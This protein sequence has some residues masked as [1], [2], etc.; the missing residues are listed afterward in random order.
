MGQMIVD[1]VVGVLANGGIRAQ[2]AFPGGKLVRV[3]EPVAAVSLERA[4]P[5]EY[6][7]VVLVEILA[8]QEVGGYLCQ[9]KALEACNLLDAAGGECDQGRCLFDRSSNLFRVPIRVAFHG[10]A[11]PGNVEDVPRP[12]IVAGDMQLPYVTAFSAEQKVSGDVLSLE[13]A[14]W[15]ITV[16]EFFPWGVWNTIEPEQ[17][18]ILE[19]RYMG[20]VE[21]YRHCKWIG[22][23]RIK[24]E[25]GMRQIRK[26]I[27]QS[28]SLTGE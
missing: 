16:E 28:R 9:Q 3:T 22:W 1:K 2:A 25:L 18:F 19:L 24:E 26:G 17:P 20:R 21:Q 13:S 15:E 4:Q 27:A 14:S 6:R 11:R 8:P 12:V 5:K 10:A 23:K 7:S